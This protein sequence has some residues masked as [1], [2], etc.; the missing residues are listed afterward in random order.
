MD[1]DILNTVLAYSCSLP[2]I[3]GVIKYN[4]VDKS[5]RPFIWAMWLSLFTE[6]VL[7]FVVD[8]N[9]SPVAHV[10]FY[11]LYFVLNYFFVILFFYRQKLIRISGFINLLLVGA[12]AFFINSLFKPPTTN[13]LGEKT[14]V[15]QAVI[16]YLAVKLLTEQ[17][18]TLVK[19]LKKNALFFIACGLL[20][21]A[22]PILQNIIRIVVRYYYQLPYPKIIVLQRIFELANALSYILFFIAILLIPKIE[23]IKN[24]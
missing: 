14:V 11:H 18:F 15:F 10:G 13:L 6:T 8:Y 4:K 23:K 16:F 21:V 24:K 20:L 1:I 17:I 3:S 9:T 7:R 5:F 19:P 2:A 12:I 22:F